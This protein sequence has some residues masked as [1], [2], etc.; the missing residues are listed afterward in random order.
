MNRPLLLLLLFPTG[1][2]EEKLGEEEKKRAEQLT[3]SSISMILGSI[4]GTVARAAGEETRVGRND[5][6]T[7]KFLYV[8]YRERAARFLFLRRMK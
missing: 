8:R 5:G 6:R 7:V 4:D 3:A 1:S 2:I